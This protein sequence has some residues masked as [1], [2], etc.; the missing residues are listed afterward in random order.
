LTWRRVCPRFE[1]P[2]SLAGPL[3]ATYTFGGPLVHVSLTSGSA[4]DRLASF[5][6]ATYAAVVNPPDD[7]SP[8]SVALGWASQVTTMAMEMV[9]PIVAGYFIDRW[10]GTL[11]IF[12]SAGA[13]LGLVVGIRGLVLLTKPPRRN[14]EPNNPAKKPPSDRLPGGRP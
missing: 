4:P 10:I 3:A 7:R 13:V 6:F 8:L 12:V 2:E 1:I 5:A 14:G 11:P 9:A